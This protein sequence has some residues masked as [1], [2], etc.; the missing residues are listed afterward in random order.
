MICTPYRLSCR[1]SSSC[2]SATS[3]P[4]RSWAFSVCTRRLRWRIASCT[5]LDSTRSKLLAPMVRTKAVAFV[6]RN[7]RKNSIDLSGTFSLVGQASTGAL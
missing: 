6:I 4:R 5:A 3:E 2:M 7:F 1:F